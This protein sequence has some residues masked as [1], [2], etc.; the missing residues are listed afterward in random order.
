MENQYKIYHKED[1]DLYINVEC[2]YYKLIDAK[3]VYRDSKNNDSLDDTI[4]FEF[5]RDGE[6]QIEAIFTLGV[7]EGEKFALAL[8]NLCHSIKR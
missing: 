3:K 6:K 5:G 2:H 7:D 1:K 8:L 4:I